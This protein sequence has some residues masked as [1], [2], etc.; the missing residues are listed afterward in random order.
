MQV[1][2]LLTISHYMIRSVFLVTSVARV[3]ISF[4]VCSCLIIK[5]RFIFDYEASD[6]Q[7][8]ILL[9]N[10]ADHPCLFN[11]QV[12]TWEINWIFIM[13]FIQFPADSHRYQY[14]YRLWRGFERLH[15]FSGLGWLFP[16]SWL[17]LRPAAYLFPQLDR[18]SL[19]FL[20]LCPIR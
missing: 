13:N 17:R 16:F 10:S 15:L 8:N 14:G 9:N 4:I 6:W 19:I 1:A 3:G 20:R 7:T 11:R 18:Q 2:S 5:R 12:A